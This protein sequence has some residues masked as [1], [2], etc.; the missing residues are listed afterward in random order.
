VFSWPAQADLGRCWTSPKDQIQIGVQ[1]RRTDLATLPGDISNRSIQPCVVMRWADVVHESDGDLRRLWQQWWHAANLLLPAVNVWMCADVGCDLHA[2]ADAPAYKK[3]TMSQE[4]NAAAA[5]A[6][7]GVQQLL[8]A[9]FAEG[10][11]APIVGYELAGDDGCIVGDAE[12]GWPMAKVAVVVKDEFEAAFRAAGW[13]V[14]MHD[15]DGLKAA[16]VSRLT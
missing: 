4:W 9:L 13:E 11:V 5:V 3:I 15:M 14:F 6:A 8:A 2:L 10:V 1:G 16:L 7:A 12:L